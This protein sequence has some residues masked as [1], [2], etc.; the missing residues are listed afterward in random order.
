MDCVS[1]TSL[2]PVSFAFLCYPLSRNVSCVFACCRIN[3]TRTRNIKTEISSDSILFYRIFFFMRRRIYNNGQAFISRNNNKKQDD[4]IMRIFYSNCHW[5]LIRIY[6]KNIHF[7]QKTVHPLEC[8]KSSTVAYQTSAPWWIL[9]ILFAKSREG[10]KSEASNSYL[11]LFQCNQFTRK[12]VN[13]I[14][15]PSP[16]ANTVE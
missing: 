12:K 14:S 6:N 1:V 13:A 7:N 15:R 10:K 2:C 11:I 5:Q 8:G 16:H 3:N 9:K 4:M